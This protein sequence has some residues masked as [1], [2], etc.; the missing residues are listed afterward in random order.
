MRGLVTRALRLLIHFRVSRWIVTL[1]LLA[2]GLLL[3]L[4][5]AA[6]GQ[7]V[8][9]TLAEGVFILLCGLGLLVFTI[10]IEVRLRKAKQVEV[11]AIARVSEM[12]ASGKLLPIPPLPESMPPGIDADD[13]FTVEQYALRMAE[14]PWGEKPAFA[15]VEKAYPLFNRTVAQVREV[16]GDWRKFS[17]PI[18]TFVSLPK[19]LCFVG[20]AEIMLQLSYMQANLWAPVGLQ[21][22]LRFIARA[23]YH[24][25][26]QPDAL[27]IRIKLLAGYAGEQWVKLAE[28]TLALLK[29]VAPDHLRLPNAEFQVLV[30]RNKLEEALACNERTLANP[31]S[32]EEVHVALLDKARLLARMQRDE[33]ALAAYAELNQRYPADPWAWHN[34][35]LI[36]LKRGRYKEALACNQRALAIMPFVAAQKAG[37]Y[38][39][40]RLA[41]A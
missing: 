10:A 34:R 16:T 25:A 9:T 24:N 12:L 36:L 19:P 20:A 31:P 29:Q 17:A 1:L 41:E 33:E 11:D 8:T 5:P 37:E 14:R 4:D 40:A 18:D 13:I 28:E 7:D 6:A 26:E 39:R 27:V 35:S 23:Q 38:I 22:G 2:I 21:Q 15:T 32:S 30:Q 3:V